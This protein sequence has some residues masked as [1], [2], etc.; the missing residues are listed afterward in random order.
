MRLTGMVNQ[1]AV[2][3]DLKSDDTV[4]LKFLRITHPRFKQLVI[5]I[6]TLLD[7]PTLTLEVATGRLW[8]AEEYGVAPP[9]TDGK[10]YLT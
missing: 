10:L 5:S 6:V 3:G 1:L 8:S 4:V 2:L 7:V 9:A